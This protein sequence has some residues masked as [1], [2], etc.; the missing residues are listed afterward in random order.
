MHISWRSSKKS[1]Q[2]WFFWLFSG[3]RLLQIHL[4]RLNQEFPSE[5]SL[6]ISSVLPS[7]LSSFVRCN[8]LN[9]L[10]KK[11]GLL[12][13]QDA[14]QNKMPKPIALALV[15]VH[16]CQPIHDVVLMISIRILLPRRN[17]F[18]ALKLWS[19]LCE[20]ALR[21]VSSCSDDKCKNLG[22]YY[23]G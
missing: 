17:R 5:R 7:F 14:S 16:P 2:N 9:F 18:E 20:L 22:V 21:I 15:T 23:W 12:Y 10:S 4:F 13:L 1:V 19:N 11:N 3:K 8:G 6:I